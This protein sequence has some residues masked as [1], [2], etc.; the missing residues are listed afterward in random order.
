MSD[1]GELLLRVAG[2]AS[3]CAATVSAWWAWR[4]RERWGQVSLPA[5][6]AGVGPYR[7]APVRAWRARGTPLRVVVVSC[8]GT[9]WGAITTTVLAPAGLVFLLAPARHEPA[10]Q[11]LLTLSGLGVF[12]TA[13]A[14]L[15]LG[16]SLVLASRAL[17]SRDPD[18]LDRALTTATWSTLHHAMV[19]LSFVL[20]AVHER[21]PGIAMVVA[22]PCAIGLVHAW[23]LAHAARYVAALDLRDDD[24]E[25]L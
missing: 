13:A 9:I 1:V 15:A 20:F 18:A 8:L 24:T 17:V 3:M 12:A 7:R 23:S 2:L 4:A 25:T 16:P 6:Y 5:A 19:L 10:R 11:L 14:A 22:V 21:A